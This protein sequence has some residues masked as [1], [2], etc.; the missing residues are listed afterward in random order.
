MWLAVSRLT[1]PSILKVVEWTSTACELHHPDRAAIFD[2][3]AL[4]LISGTHSQQLHRRSTRNAQQ[5]GYTPMGISHFTK[6]RCTS[7]GPTSMSGRPAFG[8]QGDGRAAQVVRR[9]VGRAWVD[10]SCTTDKHAM[11]GGATAARVYPFAHAADHS[12]PEL[13]DDC[14]QLAAHATAHG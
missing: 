11:A 13:P 7:A 12:L 6:S 10:Y 14:R 8:R 1:L 2:P 4:D 5:L 9:T 3:I